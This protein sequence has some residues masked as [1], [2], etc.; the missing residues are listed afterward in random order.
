MR[1]IFDGRKRE[2]QRE[3]M[4]FP[5]RNSFEQSKL[6]WNL[7]DR[8]LFKFYQKVIS[9]RQLYPPKPG[10]TSDG[11]G[12]HYSQDDRWIA[13][14]YQTDVHDWIGVVIYLGKE[15]DFTL[16]H[17]FEQFTPKEILLTT[18][19]VQ[20]Q[21]PHLTFFSPCGLIVI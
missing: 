12:V 2:F 18:D 7:G 13:W 14:E 10:L 17:P 3:E 15:K 9:L 1:S 11:V 20:L 8:E 16:S 21:P 19:K 4:P 6:S 5:G